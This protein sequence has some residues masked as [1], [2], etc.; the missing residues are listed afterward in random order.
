MSIIILFYYRPQTLCI[1]V[2]IICRMKGKCSP[3][4]R[5]KAPLHQQKPRPLLTLA[6]AKFVIDMSAKAP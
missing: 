3:E 6:P 1:H 2:H 5:G 4:T